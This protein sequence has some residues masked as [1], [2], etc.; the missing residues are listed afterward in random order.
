MNLNL[1]HNCKHEQ[2]K[3]EC[4]L[5]RLHNEVKAYF[6]LAVHY[7]IFCKQLITTFHGAKLAQSLRHAI[8]NNQ[9]G[10]SDKI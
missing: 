9:I 10:H 8:F 1:A 2:K 5:Y 6:D 7:S 4:G 3:R